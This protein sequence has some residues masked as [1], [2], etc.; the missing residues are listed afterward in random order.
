MAEQSVLNIS[1]KEYKKSID[2]LRASLLNLEKGSE[3]YNKTVDEIAE[4][5]GKLN[6][7]MNAGKTAVDAEANSL[8]GLRAKLSEMKSEF[9]NMEIGT[10]KWKEAQQNIGN[11]NEK[12][13]EIE[14]GM[15]VFSRNVGNYASAFTGAV[16]Q[17]GGGIKNLVPAVAGLK[18]GFIALQK[19]PIVALIA[20]IAMALMKLKEAFQ[21]SNENVHKMNQAMAPLKAVMDKVNRVFEQLA[22]KLIEVIEPIV[23]IIGKFYELAAQS[24]ILQL[25]MKALMLILDAL[26]AV[27]NAVADAVDWVVDKFNGLVD[28]IAGLG[29]GPIS[30]MADEMK[31]AREEMERLAELEAQIARDEATLA[32]QERNHLIDKANLENQIAE[33][34]AIVA[35]REGKTIQERQKA[36][37]KLRRLEYKVVDINEEELR[38]KLKIVK[39]Q[40]ELSGSTDEQLKK[41]AE[42]TAELLKQQG[43]RADI[44]RNYN[45]TN[46]RLAKEQRSANDAAVRERKEAEK[47][48]QEAA[49]KTM[50]TEIEYIENQLKYVGKGT[51]EEYDLRKQ[52]ADK[53][54]ELAKFTAQSE[55]ESADALA[56]KL[57]IIRSEYLAELR[58]IYIQQ[59]NMT[60]GYQE[61]L[62]KQEI[63]RLKASKEYYKHRQDYDTQYYN[64]RTKLLS[65]EIQKEHT[66][67]Q[68][69]AMM[70]SNDFIAFLSKDTE[71]MMKLINALPF[72]QYLQ[73]IGVE[74]RQ[75]YQEVFN[76]QDLAK[77][78]EN[79]RT[80]LEGFLQQGI[81]RTKDMNVVEQ[82]KQFGLN[83]EAVKDAAGEIQY[84]TLDLAYFVEGT[85][86]KFWNSLDAQ[87]RKGLTSISKAIVEADNAY[88]E[89]MEEIVKNAAETDWGLFAK[90]NALAISKA[91]RD[92]VKSSQEYADEMVRIQQESVNKMRELMDTY[93][94]IGSD[95]EWQK[96][97]LDAETRLTEL[98][99][100][101]RERRV[102]SLRWEAEQE[103]MFGDQW[104]QTLEQGVQIMSDGNAK[105]DE[106]YIQRIDN[107]KM[108]SS[109]WLMN[110]ASAFGFAHQKTEEYLEKENAL[111][112]LQ[113]LT[114]DR[115]AETYEQFLE[116]KKQA[117]ERYVKA[118]QKLYQR[119][120]KS[121]VAFTSGIGNLLGAV[122]DAWEESIERRAEA[123]D[124]NK[125]NLMNEYKHLQN[126]QIAA[127][128]ISTVAGAVS[129]YMN[130]VKTYQPAWVGMAIG[131]VDA[132]ATLVAG[133]AQ[134][135]T[136]R[137]QKLDLDSETGGSGGGAASTITVAGATPLLDEATDLQ[138][139]Q[140]LPMA[141]GTGEEQNSRVYILQTDLEES[142]QQV[143]VRQTST[144]F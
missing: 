87:G 2:D 126:L 76:E 33:L 72:R 24:P 55:I 7:V 12:I 17:M 86:Q 63:N 80:Y 4:K 32:E 105:I 119:D 139:L 28:I 118:Q 48:K 22:G 57:R 121:M 129:A 36:M 56:K 26:A 30:A 15:G 132:A 37:E 29:I 25:Q 39:A 73:N 51:Q 95:P 101:Q 84:Y 137:N 42:I 81:I 144:T 9:A 66:Q 79:M 94:E 65:E 45:Q 131:A 19:V 31:R 10:D 140:D 130:D 134:V 92:I 90:E 78:L 43:A 77:R 122:G 141:N 34:R 38:L 47:K 40:N 93:V 54:M 50:Q 5:Q 120:I 114:W 20:A 62:L 91:N 75:F 88:V 21:S 98:V 68:T 8:A 23:R 123:E 142:N 99:R 69:A 127:A 60:D 110:L 97:L 133:Y 71:A 111:Y 108:F 14:Q 52:L 3:D 103:R 102:E 107:M 125:E 61:A 67:L 136:I 16:N 18:N 64:A 46:A 124:A 49:K 74:F 96:N 83:P 128:I 1:L 113:H 53:R 104:R 100:Q 116:R 58:N 117:T 35:D 106:A 143:N 13:S 85:W 27:L 89:G 44:D 135:Q 11:L 59:A 41:E 109:N 6:E 115:N 138:A 112:D 70:Q 82:A